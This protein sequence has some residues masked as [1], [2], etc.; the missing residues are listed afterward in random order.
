MVKASGCRI[1]VLRA[2]DIS[3]IAAA[4]A[5]LGWDKP[6]AQYTG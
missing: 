6:P 5:A 4:F 3:T 2:D 1:R